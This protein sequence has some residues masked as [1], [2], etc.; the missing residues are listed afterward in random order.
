VFGYFE[1]IKALVSQAERKTT[2]ARYILFQGYSM[3]STISSEK[4][5][6]ILNSMMFPPPAP[7]SPDGRA[8]YLPVT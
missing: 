7:R 3:G 2:V 4:M 1:E 5:A 8:R 6:V